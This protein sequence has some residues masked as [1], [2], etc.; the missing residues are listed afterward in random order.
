MTRQ[1]NRNVKGGFTLLEVLLVLM[2]LGVLVTVAVM[3]LGGQGEKAKIQAAEIQLGKLESSLERYNLNIGHYPTEEEGGLKALVTKP[4]F[5]EEGMEDKWAGPY[6]KNKDLKDPWGQELSY[7]VLDPS[8]GYVVR[9][10]G[11]EATVAGLRE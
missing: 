10:I 1:M 11:D 2:I 9:L 8:A 7:E 5:E 4:Q 6:A 3:T